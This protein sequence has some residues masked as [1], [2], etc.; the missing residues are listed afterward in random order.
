MSDNK[1]AQLPAAEG[2]KVRIEDNGEVVELEYK[3]AMT[4]HR[5][6]LWWGTAVGYRAMQM[7][8]LA[9]SSEENLWSRKNLSLVSGHPG[10]GVLDSL[11]YVTGCKDRDQ[12]VVMENPN[13]VGKC[14][15]EMKFEWWVSND[16]KTAHVA[17]REDFVPQSFYDLTDRMVAGKTTDE[18]RRLFELFKVDLSTRIWNAP[19]DE[20]F[21]VTYMDPLKPGE[22]PEGHEWSPE[23]K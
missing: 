1:T 18:D 8:A 21:S 15:S 7:A 23:S 13:C 6:S 9:M 17:L 14:N 11:N 16:E 19:L 5:S 22:L 20:N 2:V 10:P 4:E 12:M 3:G